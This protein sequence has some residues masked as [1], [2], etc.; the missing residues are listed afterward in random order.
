MDALLFYQLPDLRTYKDL[1]EKNW[2]NFPLVMKFEARVGK[3]RN[4]YNLVETEKIV[5]DTLNLETLQQM[6]I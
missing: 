2:I 4:S 3:S 6:F 5:N 1:F